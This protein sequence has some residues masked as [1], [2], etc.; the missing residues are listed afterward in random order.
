MNG[1]LKIAHERKNNQEGHINPE[2][3][4]GAQPLTKK[5]WSEKK[6]QPNNSATYISNGMSFG[7][8]ACRWGDGEQMKLKNPKQTKKTMNHHLKKLFI[9]VSVK[10]EH[11]VEFSRRI[12]FRW[13]S[14]WMDDNRRLASRKFSD[15]KSIHACICIAL[16]LN[17]CSVVVMVFAP[18][19][20]FGSCTVERM[21]TIW[22]KTVATVEYNKLSAVQENCVVA[23]L[24]THNKYNNRQRREKTSQHLIS[25]RN[26]IIMHGAIVQMGARI[27]NTQSQN[28]L[29]ESKEMGDKEWGWLFAAEENALFGYAN[30]SSETTLFGWAT[31]NY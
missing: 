4:V 19:V 20:A 21:H 14:F 1:P 17:I 15:K 10:D 28:V 3:T 30:S 11:I 24:I 9:R 29:N 12:N 23:R 16:L 26:R 27:A 6:R 25:K 22:M 5:K 18:F 8:I 7:L 2:T 13:F 31:K